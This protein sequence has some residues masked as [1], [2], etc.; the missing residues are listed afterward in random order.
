MSEQLYENNILAKIISYLFCGLI[1]FLLTNI[2]LYD[3]ENA[4]IY[5]NYSS[6][7]ISFVSHLLFWFT[8]PIVLLIIVF[9]FSGILI[10]DPLVFFKDPFFFRITNFILLGIYIVSIS[11]NE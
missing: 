4:E 8:I 11:Y 7:P 3:P 2:Y 6:T 9:I 5:I 1:S 10:L